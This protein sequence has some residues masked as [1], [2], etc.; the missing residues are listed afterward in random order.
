MYPE[1]DSV[2]TMS[3]GVIKSSIERS[4]PC[5][6]IVAELVPQCNQF[7][8][9]DH[10]NALGPGQDVQQIDD[11]DHDGLVLIANLVLFQAGE[12]LEA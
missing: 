11:L 12:T 3:C 1:C 10:R 9:N 7:V 4:T 2:T 8:T 5:A 6:T